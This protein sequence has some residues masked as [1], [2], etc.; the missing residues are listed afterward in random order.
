[1]NVEIVGLD[2]RV[3]RHA[4][5]ADRV[6]LRIV[7]QLTVG[8]A[9]P[10]DLEEMLD[11][12]SS[13]LAHHLNVLSSAGIV[14]R[15]RSEGDRRRSYVTLTAA[16]F[17][18]RGASAVL[19][20]PRVVFVC[21]ANSARSQLAA[22]LWSRRSSVPVASA[23]THPA[24][25]V[26]PGAVRVGRLHNLALGRQKPQS[27]ADVVE[28]GDFIVTVCDVAHEEVPGRVAAHWSIPDPVRIGTDPAFEAAYTEIERRVDHLAMRLTAA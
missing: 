9:S 16:A 26:A 23:G 20:A 4:A 24:A 27:V 12:S 1:M 11:I 7:D 10:S 13:L 2:E 5:L 19:T 15:S 25:E 22:A 17:D 8:D 14:S 6:R 3:A 28:P 21:T 18:E